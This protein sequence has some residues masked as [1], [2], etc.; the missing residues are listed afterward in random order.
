MDEVPDTII[1]EP[2]LSG[3]IELGAVVDHQIERSGEEWSLAP[4]TFL[5]SGNWEF[6]VWIAEDGDLLKGGVE[7]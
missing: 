2:D 6:V 7:E 5:R 4:I 3:E 1:A